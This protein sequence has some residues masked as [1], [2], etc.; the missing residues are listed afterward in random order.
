MP[1]WS[2]SSRNNVYG[3]IESVPDSCTNC[4]SAVAMRHVIDTTLF[5][6]FIGCLFAGDKV[7]INVRQSNDAVR[8]DLLDLTPVG[9]SIKELYKF[10]QSR[11]KRDSRI[12]GGPEEAHPFSRGLSTYLGHYYKPFSLFPTVVQAFWD[13]DDHGKLSNIWVRR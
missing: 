8:Q 5:C 13:F 4:G 1:R 7:T 3:R 12:V 11:V 9:M 10:L 2:S 6:A